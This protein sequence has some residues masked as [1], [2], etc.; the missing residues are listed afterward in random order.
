ML[1][2]YDWDK[3]AQK[4]YWCNVGPDHIVIFLQENNHR[5]CCLD[6]PQPILHM[7]ITSAMLARSPQTTLHRKIIYIVFLDLPGPTLHKEITC[8]MFANG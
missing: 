5:Q 8:G 1:S 3:I 2:K 6:L 7:K 4:N